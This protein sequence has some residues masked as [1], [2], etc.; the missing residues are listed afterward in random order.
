M[1][2]NMEYALEMLNVEWYLQGYKFQSD[3]KIIS[4]QSFDMI[5][6]MD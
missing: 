1:G 4:L 6:G 3:L 5:L 2:Q